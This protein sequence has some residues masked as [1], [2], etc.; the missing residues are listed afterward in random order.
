M[1]PVSFWS[2]F[3]AR[4]GRKFFEGCFEA[5]AELLR[6]TL[7]KLEIVHNS[8]VGGLICVEESNAL[9]DCFPTERRNNL[10]KQD[11]APKLNKLAV[12][13]QAALLRLARTDLQIQT[14][15]SLEPALGNPRHDA[16]LAQQLGVAT[17]LCSKSILYRAGAL[18]NDFVYILAPDLAVNLTCWVQLKNDCFGLCR[19]VHRFAWTF[20]SCSV[21]VYLPVS[22]TG[23]AFAVMT[24]ADQIGLR[25]RRVEGSG[26]LPV[27]NDKVKVKNTFIEVSEEMQLEDVGYGYGLCYR[28]RIGDGSAKLT[29]WVGHRRILYSKEDPTMRFS[30]SD[31]TPIIALRCL[32]ACARLSPAERH[33]DLDQLR[34]LACDCAAGASSSAKEASEHEPSSNQKGVPY[35]GH[36]DGPTG[37][38]LEA[39]VDELVPDSRRSNPGIF[40]PHT[41]N[42]L[43]KGI[44]M[45]PRISTNNA[46]F[47]SS[48][49]LMTRA[50]KASEHPALEN[51]DVDRYVRFSN[52]LQKWSQRDSRNKINLRG[53]RCLASVGAF[54]SDR[55]IV[56][57]LDFNGS[58]IRKIRQIVGKNPVILVG[59]KIDS[60]LVLEVCEF[61]GVQDLLPPK[62]KLELVEKWL[63]YIL[64][65]KK[66]R[67]VNAA[68]RTVKLVS[69]ETGKHINHAVNAIIEARS[70]M[71][72]FVVGA[73]NAGKSRFIT[74]LLDRLEASSWWAW[75]S[76]SQQ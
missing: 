24:N 16:T 29:L 74:R 39:M 73:A 11:V 41:D 64:R 1:M 22:Y 45:K 4:D 48:I 71:D 49:D 53:C 75:E 62:T 19:K 17:A 21:I 32:C 63:L 38:E 42:P 9:A 70:G 59:T 61:E 30:R 69:N 6:L 27:A 2:T 57:V 44:A 15:F 34:R 25:Q 72:V 50:S 54:F 52:Y 10:F 5:A 47:L 51:S 58:F 65:K 36:P 37:E 60:R 18:S 40:D 20:G 8:R 33:D 13:E 56:D 55:Y 68:W 12:F 28:E 67:V 76:A 46:T 35:A 3:S 66:L 26:S 31:P 7:M 14:S 43:T 23:R